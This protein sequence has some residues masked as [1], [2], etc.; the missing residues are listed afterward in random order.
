MAR[1]ALGGGR[2]VDVADQLAVGAAV[3]ADVDDHRARLDPVALDHLGPCRWPRPPRR[4]GATSPARSRVREWQTV[5]V[6]S[7]AVSSTAI[8]LPTMFDRPS[9]TALRAATAGRRPPPAASSP[10]TACRR[11]S[12]ARPAAGG[13]GC[14]GGSRRRPW[15]GRWPAAPCGCRSACGSGSCTRMPSTSR[16]AFSWRD[17]V[18]QRRLAGVGRQLV[19]EGAD[20]RLLAG[21]G[22]VADVDLGRGILAH[23]HHRQARL[24][25]A[26][27]P[28]VSRPRR[29]A[30]GS[31][32]PAPCRR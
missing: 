28:A 22:L 11:R 31:A 26:A 30:A 14:R 5:T 20:A 23:Q 9:T 17:Q 24:H 27:P 7:A 4:R 6:A 12:A 2:E 29:S 10:R 25:A 15:P 32:A 8:G 18:Q 19:I 1:G 21:L 16:L 3:G 13:R